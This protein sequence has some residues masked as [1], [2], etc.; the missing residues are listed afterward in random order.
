MERKSRLSDGRAIYDL[1]CEMEHKSLPYPQFAAIY[2]A[3]L[4][5]P[6]YDCLVWEQVGGVVGVLNLRYEEQLHHAERV[7]EIL[8]FAIAPD[9]RNQGLGKRL[10]AAACAAASEHGCSQIEAACNQLRQDTHRFYIREG[11]HNF[12]FKFSKRLDGENGPE[13][14]LGR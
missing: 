2:Q 5:D 12:H 1:I 7:A 4:E 11:M 13:N 3:Q 14:A 10:L 8:E 9:F 6:R